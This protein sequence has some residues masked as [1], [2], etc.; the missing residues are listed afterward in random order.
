MKNLILVLVLLS[1]I[2]CE[3]SGG[4]GSE[5]KQASTSTTDPVIPADPTPTPAPTPVPVPPTNSCEVAVGAAPKELKGLKPIT[6]A[7]LTHMQNL[8][9]KLIRRIRPNKLGLSRINE[10]RK[11]NG[12]PLLPD[13][14]ASPLGQDTSTQ[15]EVSEE[16]VGALPS[17]LDNSTMSAFP[18]IGQ[19]SVNNCAAW[20]M[21]YY[22]WSHNNGL[23]LGWNNKSSA[24]YRCSPKFVYNMINDGVDNGAYFSD[25]LNM[26]TKH[27]CI[28]IASFPEDGDYRTWDTNPAHWQAAIPFRASTFQYINNVDT[29]TGLNQVKQLLN[30]GYVLTYGTYINSWQFT[31]IKANPASASNPLAGQNVLRYMN[32]TD[33]GHAMTIVGYDDNAWTDINQNNV[34]D[35]GELGV[36]KVANSWGTAWK[37]GGYIF[38]AYDALKSVSAVTGGPSSGRQP[39]FMSKQ[40][41]HLP[42]K[43]SAGTAYAP[44]YLAKFTV[45]HAAR[46]QL[47]I[48][49]SSGSST[50][51]PF[52]MMNK[53]G[54]NSFGGMVVMDVSD[55]G[56]SGSDNIFSLTVSDNASGNPA[57]V[58]SFEIIDLVHSTQSASQDL[59]SA[60]SVD[61]TSKTFKVAFTSVVPNSAPTARMTA[62][63]LSGTVP[64]DVQFDGSGTTDPDGT[65]SSYSW[66]FGDGTS[67]TGI[68]R[69]KTFNTAGTFTVTLTV[70][71]NDGATSTTSK[72]IQVNPVVPPAP[73]CN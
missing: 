1:F 65:I 44:K 68:S 28:S 53:G 24:T 6:A 51:T 12:L 56:V 47:S 23:A 36:L 63:V 35:A 3:K 48:K 40:V 11:K 49:F 21:G 37:N 57:T 22:Q 10:H 17:T 34:V 25:A 41:Y 46:N 33:G 26:V 69:N 71:D 29:D 42:V 61:G 4:S 31:T 54:A 50:Y 60:A 2:S 58:S 39:V 16:L 15:E 73:V 43:P 27:G 64:L 13:S 45:N 62:S 20:A 72:V 30:N 67:S 32:G 18:P 7:E 14:D 38:V 70:K 59:V 19:Q 9:M 8:G 55:L 66:N 52:A 5:N